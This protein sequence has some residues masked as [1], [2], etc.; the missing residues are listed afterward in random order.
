MPKPPEFITVQAAIDPHTHLRQPSPINKAETYAKG[1]EAALKGGYVGIGDISNTLGRP[2]KD[3]ETVWEKITIGRNEA[4][5]PTGVW[6]SAQ[7]EDNGVGQL[8][9]VRSWILGGKF[10]SHP[11]TG[12]DKYHG[13]EDLREFAVELS[14]LDRDLPLAVH[15]GPD[16]L[17]GFIDLAEELKLHLYIFHMNNPDDVDLATKAI[18]RGVRITREISPHHL[19][20]TEEEVEPGDW[21]LRM[22]PPLAKAIDREKLLWQAMAGQIDTIGT[23]HAPHTQAAKEEAGR[24][25]PDGDLDNP[26]K[27]FGVRSLSIATAVVLSEF[28]KH[29]GEIKD[30]DPVKRFEEM[31]STNTAGAIDIHLSK[32][33]TTTYQIGKWE[34]GPDDDV[35]LPEAA[36]TPFIGHTALAKV[37]QV[38][39]KGRALFENG[40][41]VRREPRLLT[42]GVII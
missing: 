4:W 18:D 2:T 11:S 26:N 3:V 9:A 30:F 16:N 6:L 8:R 28:M 20:F 38:Q 40:R 22:Q 37:V 27:A 41:I 21:S 19:I 17:E 13:P 23:D 35:K 29:E 15:A 12:N 24:L 25:N 36:P 31:T 32:N 33:T 39:I 10:F 14:K 7:P 34:I 5:I 42:R 1:T